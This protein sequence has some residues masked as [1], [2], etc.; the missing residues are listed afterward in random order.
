MKIH[1]LAAL[2]ALGPAGAWSAPIAYDE[3]VS[4]DIVSD[5]PFEGGS[6]AGPLFALDVGVNT[7]TGTTRYTVNSPPNPDGLLQPLKDF[8]FFRV[9][10]PA[11]TRLTGVQLLWSQFAPNGSLSSAFFESFVLDG[12][13]SVGRSAADAARLSFLTAGSGSTPVWAADV[14]LGPGTYDL[15]YALGIGRDQ[16]SSGSQYQVGYQWRFTVAAV[17]APEPGTFALL[18][19][20]LVGALVGMRSR[21]AAVVRLP[22]PASM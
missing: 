6:V 17:Q 20:G 8:D 4:G 9:V 22:G 12:T 21:P 15:F 13:A 16:D 7:V 1:A 5:S 10:V 18:A 11:G 19:I 14:P 3:A 2:L